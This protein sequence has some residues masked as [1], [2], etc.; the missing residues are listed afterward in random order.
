MSDAAQFIGADSARASTGKRN[1]AVAVTVR[2]EGSTHEYLDWDGDYLGGV[3]AGAHD[4]A[5]SPSGV[6]YV[7]YWQRLTYE[8]GKTTERRKTVRVYGRFVSVTGEMLN[9][10]Y[11]KTTS[12]YKTEAAAKANA[13]AVRGSGHD[14]N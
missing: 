14:D 6:L 3:G 13:G 1:D 7:V 5:I 11:A 9:D 2:L 8:T 12:Q 4:F 10:P